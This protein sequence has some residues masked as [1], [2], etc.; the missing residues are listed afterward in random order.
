MY[1]SLKQQLNLEV[2][3]IMLMFW[4]SHARLPFGRLIS[5]AQTQTENTSVA[6]R[7]EARIFQIHTLILAKQHTCSKIN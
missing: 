3:V 7:P 6:Y 2:A 4:P 1:V 5:L